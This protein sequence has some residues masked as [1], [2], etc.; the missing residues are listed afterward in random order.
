MVNLKT[1]FITSTPTPKSDN[2]L[3]V[4][5][6]LKDKKFL[7]ATAILIGTMVGVGIFGIPFAF[8]KSGFGIGLLFLVAIGAVTLL[9]NLIYGE[10]ILRTHQSHQLVGYTELYLGNT[11]KR[12]I[13]FSILLNTYA[14]LLAYIIISGEFLTTVLAPFTYASAQSLSIWFFVAASLLVFF[15]L[16]TVA[17]VELGISILFIAVIFLIFGFGFSKINFSNFIGTNPSM[18]FFPY[19]VFLFA[20]GGLPAIPIQ[21]QLLGGDERRFKRSIFT[22]VLLVGLL[23]FLFAFTVFGVSGQGTSPDAITGLVDFI[24]GKIIF[25]SSLFGVLAVST[26]YLML[27]TGLFQ[28]FKLDYGFNKK[29]SWALVILPPFLLF[30]G[31]LRSFIDVIGLAG[32]VAIGLEAFIIILLFIKAK[33]HG[34]RLPEYSL[35]VPVWLLYILALIFLGGVGY[36]FWVR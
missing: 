25:L 10:I 35:S 14:A 32:G 8:A 33:S 6:F 23:Y 36:T 7:H 28:I 34:D 12:V 29:L 22:G 3:N 4:A 21:R 13:F 5:S 31:G 24:G 20:F 19:G 9:L 1:V 15:G 11:W 26:S 2:L 30:L 16:R 27:G 18:W 17:W